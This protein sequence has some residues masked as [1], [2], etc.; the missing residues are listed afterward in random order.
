VRYG[1]LSDIHSNLF[2]LEVVLKELRRHSPDAYLCVGDTVG[3]GSR[4]NECCA[5]VRE[6][7]AQAVVGNHDVAAFR[8]GTENWFNA[9]AR[10]AALWTRGELE[11][12]HIE[13]LRG[14]PEGVR[15]EQFTM[16]HGSLHDRWGYISSVWEA[17]ETFALL[18][19]P[20]CLIGHTHYAEWY[21]L[22]A[23]ATLAVQHVATG[24][25]ICTTVPGTRYVVNPGSVG[26][27]RDSDSRASCAI[28]DTEAGTIQIIRKPYNVAAAQQDMLEKGLPPPLAKR[29]EYGV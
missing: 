10:A 14:L 9:Q 18:E 11:P 16:V 21:E 1:I 17:Q 3:Y 24:G 26:Q 12:Q 29:L 15:T 23:G 13:Y 4:P 6:L 7:A 2:A 5:L 8:N 22:A 19:S 27:P 28:W 20:V 25:G